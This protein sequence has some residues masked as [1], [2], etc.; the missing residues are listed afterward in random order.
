MNNAARN[1]SRQRMNTVTILL[2]LSSMPWMASGQIGKIYI[3]GTTRQPIPG[4]SDHFEFNSLDTTLTEASLEYLNKFG[5]FYNDS[6]SRNYSYVITLD[7]VS[8]AEEKKASK[9]ISHERLVVV[10]NYL[11]KNFKIDSNKFRARYLE[12][13]T[14]SC[15]AYIGVSNRPTKKK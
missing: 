14:F 13:I 7:Q 5:V 9:Y 2:F 15:S 3:K 12:T 4:E 11:E 8:T 6:L 10:F 1:A